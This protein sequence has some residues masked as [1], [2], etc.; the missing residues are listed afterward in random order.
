[1]KIEQI[2]TGCLAQGAYYIE[3]NG[4]AAI[5]DP[6]RE[7]KPYLDRLHK[8]KAKL[9]YVLET[10]FHADFVSGHLDLARHTGAK[11]VYGPS[12]KA[13]FDLYEAKDNEML[14]LGNVFIKVLHT[15][16]HTMESSCFLVIDEH[17]KEHALFSGDT[18]FIGDVGRPDLAQKGDITQEVLAGY[19]FDSLRN[20]VMTLQ[21]DVIVYPGHGAG[22]ACG[23]NMSSETIDTIGH[24]LKNNYALRANM[25][26]EEFV[27]EVLTG[28][29][30]PPAY[31]P[32]NAAMNK[33]DSQSFMEV[34]ERGSRPLDVASFRFIAEETDALILDT[35]KPEEF[36]NGFIPGSINIGLDGNF[37]PWAGALIPDL[38][39]EI[40]LVTEPGREEE[41]ITR[42][43]R[44]GFDYTIGYLEGG[45]STYL[46]SGEKVDSIESIDVAELRRRVDK[47][48]HT[49][50]L[51]VRRKSEYDAEH[52]LNTEVAPLD[53]INESMS[54]I[55]KNQDTF[56]YCAGGY[57]SVI[58]ISILKA[59]GF[60]NLINVK[61]GFNAIKDSGLFNVSAFHAPT[62]LL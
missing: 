28:L 18:L 27:K 31:F 10:H 24:Q 32:K 39:Q 52:V 13:E 53:Y 20:K 17:G 48:P 23:K 44:V 61:G 62:S 45:F 21:E 4:E 34:M 19:L 54:K 40:L 30:P 49:A 51:D 29:M 60:E 6:L 41:V 36:V 35:R 15:P 47:D 56:V 2:Y 50:L 57:R 7:Y 12:A 43:S 8:S 55:H 26:R 1:M 25:T 58:F 42:L 46:A 38:K 22:S 16:G 14:P 11:I 3:S 33:M 9:K 37:A 59:R 5:V